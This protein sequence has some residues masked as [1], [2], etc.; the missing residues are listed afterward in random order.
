MG[1]I[2]FYH[3]FS[4]GLELKWQSLLFSGVGIWGKESLFNRYLPGVWE[5][6]P[7]GSECGG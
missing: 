5:A 3:P 2:I 7:A 1:C 6:A 4:Y